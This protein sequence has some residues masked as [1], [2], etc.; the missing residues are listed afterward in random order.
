MNTY[1][2]NARLAGLFFLIATGAG[3]MSLSLIEVIHE[4]DYLRGIAAAEEQFLLGG[5][6][7]LIMAFACA[8][9][10]VWI[11]P[12]VKEYDEGLAVGSLAF[13][14]M[15]AV[16][17]AF[18]TLAFLALL[19]LSR[20]YVAA[21]APGAAH[22]PTLGT[23]LIGMHEIASNLGLVAFTLG[24][25]MYYVVFYRVGLLPRWLSGWGIVAI[26][27][28]L[29]ASLYVFFGGDSFSPVAIVLNVPIAIQE[30]VLAFWLLVKGFTLPAGTPVPA[31]TDVAYGTS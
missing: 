7:L 24:A 16:L 31:S 6:L 4:P 17:H 20:A 30:M 1:R 3:V 13:R 25:L 29:G 10:A 19:P 14:L 9:I 5:L 12:V 23:V 15:E 11:Y 2:L 8:A 27:L 28:C 18:A 26:L 21:G 22:F